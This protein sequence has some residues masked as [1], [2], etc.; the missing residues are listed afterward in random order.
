PKNRGYMR[1]I[2]LEKNLIEF[3]DLSVERYTEIIRTAFAN[4]KKIREEMIPNVSR[5]KEKARDTAGYLEKY[6]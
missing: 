4:R 3:R 5:E 1:T 6:F 2:G